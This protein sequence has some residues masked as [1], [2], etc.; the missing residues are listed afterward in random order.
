MNNETQTM[1]ETQEQIFAKNFF[2]AN[3]EA[4]VAD[5]VEW[6]IM[7]EG[8]HTELGHALLIGRV[9]ALSSK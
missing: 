5:L 4:G 3:P 2:L 6:L 1:K 8:Q 7:G 9:Q